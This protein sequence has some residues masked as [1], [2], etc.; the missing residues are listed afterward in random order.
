MC[1]S[2]INNRSTGIILTRGHSHW[3]VQALHNT[4]LLSYFDAV[5]DTAG[6]VYETSSNQWF[7]L[8]ANML[9]TFEDDSTELEK[10]NFILALCHHLKRQAIYVDDNIENDNITDDAPKIHMIELPRD[11][12]GV[13][14]I[15]VDKVITLAQELDEPILIFDFDCT[16]TEK[17]FYKMCA[18]LTH[19]D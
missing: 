11:R 5:V 12:D 15:S 14:D 6:N 4:G 19:I 17:H 16:L 9:T 13:D 2:T 3:V 10:D 7:S 18:G 8:D 1:D